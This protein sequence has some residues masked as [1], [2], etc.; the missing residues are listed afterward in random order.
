M[1][2]AEKFSPTFARERERERKSGVAA[3]RA[4]FL[5]DSLLPPIKLLIKYKLWSR[6]AVA[7]AKKNSDTRQ[8]NY[9]DHQRSL[10]LLHFFFFIG[11]SREWLNDEK[12]SSRFNHDDDDASLEMLFFC[13]RGT[14]SDVSA[15]V[16]GS[17]FHHRMNV[18]GKSVLGDYSMSDCV[19]EQNILRMTSCARISDDFAISQEMSSE[20]CRIAI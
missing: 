5:H 19:N 6:F 17:I 14:E 8:I 2:K 10:F 18:W 15:L 13:S 3:P 7:F 4:Q 11:S 12:R 20:R 9:C 16:S 1:E